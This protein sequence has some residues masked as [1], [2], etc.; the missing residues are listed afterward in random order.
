MVELAI[1]VENLVKHYSNTIAVD[2]IN[3]AVT[4]SIVRNGRSIHAAPR[5]K[6]S[7]VKTRHGEE[8]LCEIESLERFALE[9]CVAVR[10]CTDAGGFGDCAGE[11]EFLRAKVAESGEHR[12]DTSA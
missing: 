2:R 1:K 3:F 6:D 8:S 10:A 12:C 4:V 7:G 11:S 9:F 5:G